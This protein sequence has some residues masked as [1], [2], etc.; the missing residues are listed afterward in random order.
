[1]MTT[2]INMRKNTN[3]HKPEPN[4]TCEKCGHTWHTTTTAYR[5][6]CAN[7]GHSTPNPQ[8]KEGVA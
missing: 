8:H 6:K 4:I 2:M 1:M 5:T 7:C 3:W